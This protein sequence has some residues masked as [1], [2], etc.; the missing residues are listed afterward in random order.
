[1]NESRRE[2]ES[3]DN[4][5]D[6]EKAILAALRKHGPLPKGAILDATGLSGNTVYNRTKSLS[7]AG[8]LKLKHKGT[9]T[10]AIAEDPKT[11]ETYDVEV[12]EPDEDGD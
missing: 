4:L 7:Q 11:G 6:S 9:R 12:I 10:W 1:M 2:G 5:L 3:E 8:V